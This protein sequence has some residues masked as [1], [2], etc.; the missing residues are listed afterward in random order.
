MGNCDEVLMPNTLLAIIRS[1]GIGDSTAD[2][3]D[4]REAIAQAIGEDAGTGPEGP[5]DQ[6]GGREAI[7]GQRKIIAAWAKAKGLA[8]TRLPPALD[9]N[10]EN[11]VGGAEHDVWPDAVSQRWIK[12]TKPSFG[13]FPTVLVSREYD[14]SLPGPTRWERKTAWT[15]SVC[16]P[17]QYLEKLAG[18]KELFGI[19]TPIH[20][21]LLDKKDN[22]SMIV[23]QPTF[24]GTS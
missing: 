7:E 8:M 24:K 12:V 1:H 3:R 18:T 10:S 15:L 6:R 13:V 11:N 5:R 16:T 23:S 19:D 21:V 4:Y 17:A 20:G 22:P 14:P 9:F 2:Q